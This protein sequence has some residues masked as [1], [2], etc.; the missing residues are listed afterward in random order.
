MFQPSAIVAMQWERKHI[1]VDMLDPPTLLCTAEEATVVWE[2]T[3]G[4][5]CFLGACPGII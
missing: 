5:Q 1:S 3:I 2:P 4:R